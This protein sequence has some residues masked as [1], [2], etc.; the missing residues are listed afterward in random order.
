M[1]RHSIMPSVLIE[2]GF[3]SNKDEREKMFNEA[4][5]KKLAEGI[6]EGILKT[7]EQMGL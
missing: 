5:R 7:L 2:V 3:I 4:Y 6:A 1:L